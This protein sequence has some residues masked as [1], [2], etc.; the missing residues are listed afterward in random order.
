MNSVDYKLKIINFFKKHK[1]LILIIIIAWAIVIAVNQI[2]KSI[3]ENNLTPET[4]LEIHTAV[5]EEGKGVPKSAQK[6]IENIFEDFVKF[7]NDKDYE[8]AYNILSTECKEAIYPKIE[9]FKKYVDSVFTEYKT[10]NI[11]NYSNV[12]G[13]YVY[14]LRL[15]NDILSTGMT[16]EDYRYYE[17]KCAVVEENDE[18]RLAIR[19]Y[20]T[21]EDLGIIAN[22]D[23]Y[24]RIEIASRT[25]KYDTETYNVKITNKSDNIIVLRDST[26]RDEIVLNISDQLRDLNM[27]SDQNIVIAPGQTA[28][29]NLEFTKYFDDG[30]TSKQLIFNAIRVLKSYSGDSSKRE[31]ELKNAEKLYSLKVNLVNED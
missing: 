15:L 11:Q 25:L 29:L 9:D 30:R 3:K 8:S 5:I 26:E 23:D 17:E 16:G 10:Y 13:I 28:N 2:L 4:T 31:Q 7:C 18:Y 6:T 14:N 19:G 12:N 24:L 27:D 20:I 21:K 22:N 1:R